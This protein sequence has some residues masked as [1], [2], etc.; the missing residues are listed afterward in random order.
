MTNGL[1]VT[2]NVEPRY[3]FVATKQ[4]QHFFDT[5]GHVRRGSPLYVR[6]LLI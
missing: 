5:P 3:L 2:V 1:K 6:N 4:G